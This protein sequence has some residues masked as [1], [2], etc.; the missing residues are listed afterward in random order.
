MGPCGSTSGVSA[1]A[2]TSAFK[3]SDELTDYSTFFPAGTKS[4]LAKH[5]TK[6]IWEEYKDQS[7]GSGVTFKTCVFSGVKNL[8]SGIG[9]YAG[10]QDSYDK[11]SKLF[12]AVILDYHKGYTK[13]TGHKSDMSSEG[14]VN[15]EFSEEDAAMINSTRIRVGRNLKGYPLGPG[16]SKEQRLEIMNKVVEAAAKFEGDLA[17][18]F[19]P[20]EGMKKET[21]EQLIE[22]HFLFK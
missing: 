17:G 3:T 19:Y 2:K 20:L 15:G 21:Q 16:V 22:D 9:L 7:D 8:D 14:L 6:E 11:F 1:P 4:L 18:T 13:E 5:M 10:S 12:E